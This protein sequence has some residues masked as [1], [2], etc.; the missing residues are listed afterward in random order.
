MNGEFSFERKY[1]MNKNERDAYIAYIVCRTIFKIYLFLQAILA[2]IYI[3][4]GNYWWTAA[5][6]LILIFPRK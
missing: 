6:L 5:L 4:P 1:S 3:T 2:P